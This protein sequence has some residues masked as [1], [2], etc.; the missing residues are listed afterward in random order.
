MNAAL[1]KVYLQSPGF[2]QDIGSFFYKGLWYERFY[3]KI[4]DADYLDRGKTEE[5]QNQSLR[6]IV[7]HCYKNVPF[8]RKAFDKLKLKPKDVKV[9]EDLDK[10]PVVS[11]EDI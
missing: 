7:R 8:Y 5:Q 6:K 11:R 2:V 1:K 3:K 10:L 9:K 4:K